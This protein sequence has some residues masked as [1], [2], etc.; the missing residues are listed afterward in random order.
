MKPPDAIMALKG[1]N[2]IE[3]DWLISKLRGMVRLLHKC[4]TAVRVTL[5]Q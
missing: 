5:S 2:G 3:P 1:T 4:G